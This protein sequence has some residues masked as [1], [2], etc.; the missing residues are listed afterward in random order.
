[1]D[2][3]RLRLVVV[4]MVTRALR[5]PENVRATATGPFSVTY[6]GDAPGGLHLTVEDRAMLGGLDGSPRQ[7]AFTI[8]T[9][10]AGAMVEGYW[11]APDTWVP[12]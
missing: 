10:P 8:D 7:R 3:D 5:N 9:M 4:R 11:S 12:L 1:M 2:V 6:A